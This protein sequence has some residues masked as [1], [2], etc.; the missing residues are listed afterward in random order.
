MVDHARHGDNLEFIFD[1]AKLENLAEFEISE[2]VVLGKT[3]LTFDGVTGESFRL[4]FD[5][6]NFKVIDVPE[7][8]KDC[9]NEIATSVVDD[10]RKKIVIGGL[11]ERNG[12]LQ[13]TEYEIFYQECRVQWNSHITVTEWQSGKL[14]ND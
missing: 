5:K 7:K 13:W 3:I 8:M 4:Y 9:W 11:M 14:P 12:V 2:G 1:W 10:K 6:E